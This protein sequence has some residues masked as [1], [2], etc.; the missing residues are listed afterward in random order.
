MLTDYEFAGLERISF[1]RCGG[2]RK[3]LGSPAV[4]ASLQGLT[5]HLS[6]WGQAPSAIVTVEIPG[7]N[8]NPAKAPTVDI[9]HGCTEAR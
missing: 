2:G 3:S 7:V 9:T 1:V 5:S 8:V 6:M 4:F